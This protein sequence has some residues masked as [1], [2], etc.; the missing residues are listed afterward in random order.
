MISSEDLKV[1]H[2]ELA[3]Y[4]L[5]SSDQPL[6]SGE[7]AELMQT[8][9]LNAMHDDLCWK[10]IDAG[11]VAGTLKALANAGHAL[12]AAPVRNGRLGRDQERWQQNHESARAALPECP[13]EAQ[14]HAP[15]PASC[16]QNLSP[17]LGSDPYQHLTR[18]QLLAVVRIQDEVC[19]IAARFTLELEAWKNRARVSL[20]AAGTE[21][22][23]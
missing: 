22:A 7:C 21:Q 3:L 2:R 15:A 16:P 8:T 9:A 1:Y 23:E 12:K 18:E 10:R 11:K 14:A 4:C 17:A 20:A 6:T 5:Q 13:A 19:E